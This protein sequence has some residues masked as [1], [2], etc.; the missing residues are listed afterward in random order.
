VA[1]QIKSVIAV[2]HG[3]DDIERVAN[4]LVD[5]VV[6]ELG[7][8]GPRAGSIAPLVRCDGEAARR[9]DCRDLVIPEMS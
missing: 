5:P 1:H 6:V 9:R 4:Q 8:I 2:P 7:G 3:L